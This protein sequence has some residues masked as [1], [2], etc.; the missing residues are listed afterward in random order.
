MYIN[1]SFTINP[2]L[3]NRIDISKTKRI[4]MTNSIILVIKSVFSISASS[5]ASLAIYILL[6]SKLHVN[7]KLM[8]TNNVNR[9]TKI[10]TTLSISGIPT[11]F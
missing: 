3:I 11:C 6:P 5:L 7:E 1:I 4:R 2:T 8:N 9:T 10:I